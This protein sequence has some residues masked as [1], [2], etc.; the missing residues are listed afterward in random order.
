[1]RYTIPIRRGG[2]LSP[3]QPLTTWVDPKRAS[4]NTMESCTCTAGLCQICSSHFH[5]FSFPSR[6]HPTLL[7]FYPKV[8]RGQAPVPSGGPDLSPWPP[9]GTSLAPAR[10]SGIV[11]APPW[12][13]LG[14]WLRMLF[15]WCVKGIEMTSPVSPQTLNTTLPILVRGNGHK[16]G[17]IFKCYEHCGGERLHHPKSSLL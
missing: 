9:A 6:P 4:L 16:W 14:P 12:F 10:R 3:Q 8:K 15:S 2:F 17:D 5:L 7:S 11:A 1:M 13:I